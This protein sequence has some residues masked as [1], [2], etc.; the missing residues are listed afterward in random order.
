MLQLKRKLKS[1]HTRLD[2]SMTNS[3]GNVINMVRVHQTDRPSGTVWIQL[4]HTG[5]KTRLE[6]RQL[7]VQGIEPTWTPIKPV[8]T[9]LL[10]AE[11]EQHKFL[12]NSSHYN[13]LQLKPFTDHKVIPILKF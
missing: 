3:A 12:E 5:T 1:L 2:D 6:N 9:E 8:T 11:T 7:H 10:L 13:L 4:D